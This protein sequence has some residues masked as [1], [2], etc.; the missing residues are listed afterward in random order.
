MHTGASQVLGP[1]SLCREPEFLWNRIHVAGLWI[2]GVGLFVVAAEEV[3]GNEDHDQHKRHDPKDDPGGGDAFMRVSS[4]DCSLT[5]TMP[6]SEG[7]WSA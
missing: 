1:S 2:I 7:E 4:H 5:L 6:D 3:E